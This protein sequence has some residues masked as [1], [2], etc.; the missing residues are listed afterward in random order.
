V[1]EAEAPQGFP[2]REGYGDLF[3]P[4]SWDT[5][6]ARGRKHELQLQ[7]EKKSQ[8]QVV[9]KDAKDLD[10]ICLSL[11]SLV[12]FSV[13]D[14]MSTVNY[15]LQKDSGLNRNREVNEH[16]RWLVSS[17]FF[18]PTLIRNMTSIGF[19]KEACVGP[20]LSSSVILVA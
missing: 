8:V 2:F 11:L 4:A 10:F 17:F 16:E 7:E 12:G 20:D 5:Q 1:E 6:S 9:E 18:D 13:F 15:L 19:L 3:I 14:R